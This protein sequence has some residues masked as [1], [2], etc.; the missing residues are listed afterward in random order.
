VL[1]P[2]IFGTD[3]RPIASMTAYFGLRDA[4]G[5]LKFRAAAGH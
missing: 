5:N 3:D 2:V 4:Y 1:E